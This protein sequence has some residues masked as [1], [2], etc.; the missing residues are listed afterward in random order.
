LA[1]WGHVEGRH[2]GQVEFDGIS[3]VTKSAFGLGRRL[4]R[5]PGIQLAE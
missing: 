1:G 5:S 2:A 4:G 3:R